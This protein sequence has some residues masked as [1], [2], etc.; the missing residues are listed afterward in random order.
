M[1]NRLLPWPELTSSG[2]LWSQQARFNS[3]STSKPEEANAQKEATKDEPTESES[4]ETEKEQQLMQQLDEMK[5]KHDDI[6]D[7]YRRSLAESDNMRK[8]LTKQIEDAKVFGIQ[9]FCKDLMDVADVLSKAVAEVP[10]E[11]LKK[12]SQYLR[13][14]HEGLKL[15][16]SQLLQVFKRHGLE[17]VEPNVGDKFDPNMHEALF[18]GPAPAGVEPGAIMD[19]QKVGYSLHGRTVRPALVGVAKK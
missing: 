1:E 7:K 8:R 12:E 11:T 15:T 3:S 19:L 14:V 13:D 17:K 2:S 18:Q 4:K 10:E 9:S 5:S 16:E 6:M